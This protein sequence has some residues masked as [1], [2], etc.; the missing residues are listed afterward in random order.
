MYFSAQHFW[1]KASFG[2]T[3]PHLIQ[4]GR[5]IF[6]VRHKKTVYKTMYN[7]LSLM[8]KETPPEQVWQGTTTPMAFRQYTVRN[9]KQADKETAEATDCT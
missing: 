1:F 3:V 2:T 7:V 9:S 5:K 6:A 4:I 8:Y